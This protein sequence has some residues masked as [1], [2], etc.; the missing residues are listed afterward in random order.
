[1]GREGA[2]PPPCD[3]FQIFLAKFLILNI[4]KVFENSGD[5]QFNQAEE[6]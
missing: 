4:G 6:L 5:H 1:M 2:V 3:V